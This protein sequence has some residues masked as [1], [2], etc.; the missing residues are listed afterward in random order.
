MATLSCHDWD[1]DGGMGVILPVVAAASERERTNYNRY[2]GTTRNTGSSSYYRGRSSA[3]D[4]SSSEKAANGGY[5]PQQQQGG[6]GNDTSNSNTTVYAVLL[7]GVCMVAAS[8]VYAVRLSHDQH[9]QQH[10]DHTILQEKRLNAGHASFEHDIQQQRELMQRFVTQL[11][12]QNYNNNSPLPTIVRPISG[13]YQLVNDGTKNSGAFGNL[14]LMMDPLP[15]G[16]FRINGHGIRDGRASLIVEG[17][18][19]CTGKAYWVETVTER[20]GKRKRKASLQILNTGSFGDNNSNTTL[21]G[22]SRRSDQMAGAYR[23]FQLTLL[24]YEPPDSLS[25]ID[26]GL[27]L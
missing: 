15:D 27:H 12:H 18:A 11:R 25:L 16:T 24:P 2:G 17:L 19:T 6:N 10:Q 4:C 9:E 8:M 20:N 13:T 5:C 1:H 21:K 14:S 22:R 7:L 26:P 3:N 23:T